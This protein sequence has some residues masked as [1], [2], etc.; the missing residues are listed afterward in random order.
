MAMGSHYCL[1]LIGGY[2]YKVYDFSRLR[3]GREGTDLNFT[4]SLGTH[5]RT[6]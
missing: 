5:L 1:V 4:A 3:L 2:A 6:V